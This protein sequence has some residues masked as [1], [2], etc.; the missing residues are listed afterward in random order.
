M[1]HCQPETLVV[2]I[3]FAEINFKDVAQASAR[4]GARFHFAA[5]NALDRPG[6]DLPKLRQLFLR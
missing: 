3:F 6:A 5:L 1:Q 2:G 4:E